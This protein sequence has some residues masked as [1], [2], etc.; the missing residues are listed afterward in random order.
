M[1]PLTKSAVNGTYAEYYPSTAFLPSVASA[2]FSCEIVVV[3]VG[4]S[5]P[6]PKVRPHGLYFVYYP[7]GIFFCDRPSLTHSDNKFT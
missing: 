2:T 1:L 4:H 7:V 3:I 5:R 6:I